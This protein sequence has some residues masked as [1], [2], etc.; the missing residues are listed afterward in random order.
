MA[1]IAPVCLASTAPNRAP[2]HCAGDELAGALPL[3]WPCLDHTASSVPLLVHDYRDLEQ[4]LPK[5]LS[6][7]SDGQP[8]GSGEAPIPLQ[9]HV[10]ALQA[11]IWWLTTAWAEVLTDVHHLADPPRQVRRGFDVQWAVQL[12]TPR[13]EVLAR[14]PLVPMLFYPHT[15][16]LVSTVAG[17]QG[18]LDLTSAHNRARVM[19]GLTEPTYV[20][21]GRC[22]AKGCGAA[23]LRVADGSDTVWC[24]RCGATI[25]RDDYDRL[26]NVFLRGAA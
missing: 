9:L 4:L 18:L 25:T 3:C 26:G 21:P 12:L 24:D 17:A 14:V 7:W 10:E 2:R 11:E 19:L 16:D 1:D 5:P 15:P 20:L 22:Q 6:Q 23:E 8:R 13:I